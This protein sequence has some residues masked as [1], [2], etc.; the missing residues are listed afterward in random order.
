M[1]NIACNRD[2]VVA[3][4]MLHDLGRAKDHSIFH[5]AVGADMAINLGLPSDIVNI[6]RKHTGAGLDLQDVIDVGLPPGD[7]MPSTIEEK[8][9]AHSDNMV[10]DNL[11]VPHTHSVNKLMKKGIVRG[12]L[13]IQNLHSELSKIYGA[14]LDMV[15]NI[16]GEHP[17]ITGPCGHV[18]S[19]SPEHP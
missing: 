6:I 7:Y 4:A 9:V 2:V 15:V 11:I 12:A 19:R 16:L 14:D 18:I 13:R 17:T 5:A 10:S 3:G 1:K 8:I